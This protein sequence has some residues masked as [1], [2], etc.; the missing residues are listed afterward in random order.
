MNVDGYN[1]GPLS[2]CYDANGNMTSVRRGAELERSIHYTP[3]EQ[4]RE[5]T[6]VSATQTIRFDYG[7]D[8]KRYQR[9]EYATGSG[10]LVRTVRYL[11]NVEVIDVPPG[12]G[13]SEVKRYIGSALVITLRS[14]GGGS[15]AYLY[16]DPQGSTDLITDRFGNVGNYCKPGSPNDCRSIGQRQGFDAFGLRRRVEAA[17]VWDVLPWAQRQGFESRATSR[18]YTGH[19][20][21]DPVGLVHMNGRMYDPLIGRFIQPDPIIQ[22]PY[23]TQSHN[24]YSYVLNNPLSAVDPSGN[25]SVRQ[26]VLTVAAIVVTYYTGVWAIGYLAEG[27]AGSAAMTAA[28]GGF[29]AGGLTTGTLKGALAG[30]FGSLATMGVGAAFT[31]VGQVLAQGAVGGVMSELQGG[32][33]GHGFAS[34]GMSAALNPA[35]AQGVQGDAGQLV[36]HAVLG[37]T[38]SAVAG[39]KFANGAVTAAFSYAFGEAAAGGRAGGSSMECDRAGC[40]DIAAMQRAV[41]MSPQ[42]AFEP[43]TLP[44]WVVNGATGFG[45]GVFNAITLPARLFVDHPASLADVRALAGLSRGDEGSTVY[46]ASSAVGNAVGGTALYA[47]AAF[48]YVPALRPSG[49]II[50]HPAYG[51]R[52]VSA[53]RGQFR[54]GYGRDGGPVLRAAYRD[55]GKVDIYRP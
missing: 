52:T 15:K 18:G 37:G 31:G 51:G 6:S 45:D 36:A 38:A 24:R 5:I 11:G 7:P 9:R 12:L 49:Q 22:D 20:S 33:F 42:V 8:R 44:P 46:R 2:F 3:A 26:A 17:P 28:A 47:G 4:V 30:S 53:L 50:G 29:V 48:R 43:P 32:K 35:I 14:D 23:D 39:G 55:W 19:E 54:I 1:V 21:V 41:D 40:Y 25:L 27:A 10:T 34:A 13:V 16:T